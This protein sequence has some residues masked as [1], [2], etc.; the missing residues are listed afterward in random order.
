MSIGQRFKTYKQM[1]ISL[2]A[3]DSGAAAA[4]VA[5]TAAAVPESLAC[6]TEA[7]HAPT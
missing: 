1:L 7:A 4:D 3:A 2:A 6:R 5:V